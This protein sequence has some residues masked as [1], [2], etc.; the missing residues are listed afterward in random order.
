MCT[1]DGT[2]LGIEKIVATHPWG[3]CVTVICLFVCLFDLI[4]VTCNI[5]TL[6][7]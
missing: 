4:T 3:R 1:N 7:T 6:H 5:S 2:L